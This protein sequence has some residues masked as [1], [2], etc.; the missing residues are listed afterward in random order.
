MESAMLGQLFFP[1]ARFGLHSLE[2][3]DL[4]HVTMAKVV[5]VIQETHAIYFLV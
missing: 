4:V 3:A 5:R 2:P 1:N